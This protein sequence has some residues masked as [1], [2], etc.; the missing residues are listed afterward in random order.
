MPL[1]SATVPLFATVY[2]KA[3]SAAAAQK[4]IADLRG[5]GFEMREDENADPPITGMAYSDPDLPDLSLSPAVTFGKVPKRAWLEIAATDAEI[6]DDCGQCEGTGRTQSASNLEEEDC[7]V[8][9]GTGKL[10]PEGD[11]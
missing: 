7:P 6:A 8:C 1:Y 5:T 11:G 2:V 9:D 4:M 10:S 3:K